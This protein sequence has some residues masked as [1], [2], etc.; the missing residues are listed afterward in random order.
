M[1]TARLSPGTKGQRS[2]MGV[3]ASVE[4]IAA[5]SGYWVIR[6]CDY[7]TIGLGDQEARCHAPPSLSQRSISTNTW[8]RLGWS[9]GASRSATPMCLW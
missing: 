5:W 1:K 9:A 4:R 6:P 8:L 7:V 2:A 3:E